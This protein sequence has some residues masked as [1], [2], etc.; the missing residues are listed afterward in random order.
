MKRIVVLLS[1][2]FLVFSLYAQKP[3]ETEDWSRKP[4][5]VTPGKNNLPPSDAIILYSGKQDLIKWQEENGGPVR[6]LASDSLTVTEKTGSI[7]TKQAFGDCQ[8]HVEWRTPSEVKGKGQGRGN[9]GV[10]LMN[11]YEV[12]VLDSWENETYYNGQ[13][14]SVYKQYI[15]LVNASTPPGIWQTYDIFF[16]A[17]KFKADSTLQSPGYITVVH[18]GIL[19]Q[20]H[21]ELKGPTENIGKPV[22]KY[23]DARLPLG[24]QNHGNPVS[25]R[26]IWIREL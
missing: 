9:S 21:V 10:F 20:N 13:A 7:Q 12:Q 19:I 8:L 3:E 22:Y 6:W 14:G 25:F 17:P 15:P 26:N 2:F 1:V 23:H 5:V 24:L 16:T 11:K 4:A 18:N